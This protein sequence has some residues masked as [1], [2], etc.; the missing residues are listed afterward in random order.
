MGDGR[1]LIATADLAAGAGGHFSGQLPVPPGTRNGRYEI[2]VLCERPDALYLSASGFFTVE[3]PAGQAD[4]VLR[5]AGDTRIGTAIAAS[6]DA[7]PEGDTAGAV[8]LSRSDSFADALAGT[9]LADQLGAPLLLT[10]SDHLDDAVATELQ[11]VM[12]PGPGARVYLLGGLAALGPGVESR[13]VQLGYDVVRLAGDNRYGTA[14][15]V[16]VEIGAPDR[17]LLATGLDFRDGLVAGAAAD[18]GAAF[19]AVLLTADGVMPPETAG[20]LANHTDVERFAVG[21]RAA[22]AD[23]GATPLVGGDDADT[24]RVVAEA[25]W[26]E[27]YGVGI[28]SVANFPDALSGGAHAAAFGAPLLLS[29]PGSLSPPIAGY[30]RFRKATIVIAF[31]YGGPAAVSPAV[32]D[33]AGAAIT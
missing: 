31:V 13:V 2:I 30:L 14:V 9:P 20:Y 18:A 23:P 12:A 5:I 4:P 15:K 1:G 3:S 6:Q 29:D 8:V 25:F 21:A 26:P 22:A 16:A 24:S 27:V 32:A 19:G 7:F 17:I 33:A 11:R 10:P 28:A